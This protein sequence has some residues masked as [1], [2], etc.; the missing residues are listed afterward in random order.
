M[1]VLEIETKNKLKRI[2]N[3]RKARIVDRIFFD[4][5]QVMDNNGKW[6]TLCKCFLGVSEEQIL[7]YK[8]NRAILHKEPR[9]YIDI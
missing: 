9:I 8:I 2:E 3:P 6:H 1:Y 7:V 5:L 4:L